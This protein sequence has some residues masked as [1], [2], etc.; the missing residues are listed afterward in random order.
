MATGKARK[1]LSAVVLLVLVALLA[2]MAWS[3]WGQLGAAP[4]TLESRYRTEEQ[5]LAAEV[6]S[7]IL[8]MALLAARRPP[9]EKLDVT[10]LTPAAGA[11]PGVQL[12]FRLDGKDVTQPIQ[13]QEQVW[14]P[15]SYAPLARMILTAPRQGSG[16]APALDQTLLEALLSPLP[17]VIETQNQRVSAR[18]ATSM[19]DP[20][21]HDE[22]ALVIGSLAMREAAGEYWDV[23]QLLCRMT[24]HL[25]LAD[26]LRGGSASG[27]SLSGAYADAILATMA[28][29]TAD[30]MK[31]LDTLQ[32]G[33]ASSATL[34]AWQ[35][36]L[37]MRITRDWRAMPDPSQRT[38][39]EK[40]EYFSAVK[41]TLGAAPASRFLQTAEVE[42]APDWARIT[43]EPNF[44]T[45]VGGFASEGV[46]PELELARDLWTRMHG[47]ALPDS[48]LID[49]LNRPA[50]RLV[51]PEGPQVIA[52]GTWAASIQRHLCHRVLS[53]DTYMRWVLGQPDQAQ[54]HNA[55]LDGRWGE[56][57]LYPSVPGLRWH[58]GGIHLETF[59]DA[60]TAAVRTASRRPE[61]LPAAV[62]KQ[63]ADTANYAV[64]RR[65]MPDPLS[66]FALPVPFGTAYDTQRRLKVLPDA[67]GGTLP[68]LFERDPWTDEVTWRI[69][70]ARFG[71]KPSADQIREVYGARAEY[72]LGIVRWRAEAVGAR[73]PERARILEEACRLQADNCV[74]LAAHLVPLNRDAEAARA[75]R[76]AFDAADDRVMVANSVSFLVR[77]EQDHGRAAEAQRIAEAAA[78]TGSARG[79]EAMGLLL[80]S[81]GRFPEAEDYFV[82]IERRYQSA[83]SVNLPLGFYRR[84]MVRGEAGYEAK[85]QRGVQGVFPRG[86]EKLDAATLPP[87]PADGVGVSNPSVDA[88]LGDLQAGDIVVGLD[89][90][91]V[92]NDRQYWL[93]RTFES[94]PEMTHHVWRKGKYF[95]ARG[96]FMNRYPP[97]ALETYP[98]APP[99]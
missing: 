31:Q 72:H 12:S 30:A 81:R 99:P 55:Q 38:L 66:W 16:A 59:A 79:L 91:R 26:V 62:W 95:E 45:E 22:A 92:R 53:N 98:A 85:F 20:D 1:G 48:E 71:K 37:R 56:L 97:V 73:S 67:P 24:A 58:H 25:A 80:E 77:Y 46:E 34:E 47:R 43:L 75:L 11:L 19:T 78:A 6:S 15:E 10:V 84:M 13:W 28:G 54:A 90:W 40:I 64:T 52:W 17:R 18:L 23:R 2:N 8:E 68:A 27:R 57:A 42:P 51:T 7:D 61:L 83:N 76:L 63:L 88:E 32:A 41:L 39:L 69:V 89:G 93:V 21:A 65:R 96:R 36:A 82:Q 33:V 5:W 86:L 3:R 87:V 49:A 9:A 4:A 94:R 70:D 29:R 60:L 50:A 44:S 74:E 35:R 14:A